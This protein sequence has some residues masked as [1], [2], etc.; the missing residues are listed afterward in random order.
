MDETKQRIEVDIP[1]NQMITLRRL[2]QGAQV[3]DAVEQAIATFTAGW[4]AG[5][6]LSKQGIRDISS[7]LNV[8]GFNS[9]ASLI[10]AIQK[11]LGASPRTVVFDVDESLAVM[12]HRKATGN[13]QNFNEYVKRFVHSMFRFGILDWD[14]KT[15]FFTEPEWVRVKKALAKTHSTSENITRIVEEWA[16][17]KA[18]GPEPAPLALPVDKRTADQ[19]NTDLAI[20]ADEERKKLREK[21]KSPAMPT[22]SPEYRTAMEQQMNKMT[23]P[24][25]P[26][27][28]PVPPP[29]LKPVPPPPPPKPPVATPLSEQPI[30]I[31]GSV[32][33]FD[34]PSEG[35]EGPEGDIPTF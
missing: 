26:P 22:D 20:K 18:Q 19:R 29:P 8:D 9:E 32:E 24:P 4:Q 14:L 17:M 7:L 15:I 1:R 27:V 33:H 25:K 12:I 23:E 2:H 16:H 30:D 13:D 21:P 5:I 3:K 6:E 31:T 35:D 10:A 28:P 11:R 34:E